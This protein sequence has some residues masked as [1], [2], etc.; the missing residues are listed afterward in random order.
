MVIIRLLVIIFSIIFP[1]DEVSK[2]LLSWIEGWGVWALLKKPDPFGIYLVLVV[3]QVAFVV[4]PGNNVEIQTSEEL[5]IVSGWPNK[6][7]LTIVIIRDNLI[8]CWLS[9]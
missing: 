5:F 7:A 6:Q 9:K 3:D 1:V 2:A 4:F 8:S